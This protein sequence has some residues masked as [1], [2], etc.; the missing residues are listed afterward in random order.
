V[1]TSALVICA[2]FA[3]VG[4]AHGPPSW[5]VVALALGSVPIVA[6]LATR[7]HVSF[8]S[9]AALAVVA[10]AI[11]LLAGA[12]AGAE[13]LPVD[14]G[15][16][17]GARID[18]VVQ[19]ADDPTTSAAGVRAVVRHEGRRLLAQF[20]GVLSPL[21]AD[22]L[23]GDHVRVVG[24]LDTLDRSPLGWRR[25][26]HLVGALRVER[27]A[28]GPP[29]P[30]WMRA[31]NATRRT[32]QHG[33]AGLD[34]RTA[35]LAL[36]LVIGDD[37]GQEDLDRFRFRASGLG[38]LLA[39]SGQNVA[40][41]IVAVGPVLRRL[42]LRWRWLAGSAVVA[43][44]VL[45]TRAEPSVLRAA[46]MAVIALVAASSGRPLDGLRALAATVLVLVLV[47]PMLVHS[48]GFRLSVAATVGLTL[49][50][51]PIANGLPGPRWWRE[52]LGASVAATLATLPLQVMTF[53][54]VPVVGLA[55]NVLAVPVAG[56]VVVA[57]PP[58]AL[59]AGLL[60]PSFGRVLVWPVGLLVEWIDRVATWCSRV[61]VGPVDG[62]RAAVVLAGVA[63]LAAAFRLST[64]HPGRRADV[65]LRA[66]SGLV[67]VVLAVTA[68]VPAPLDAGVHRV[69][70]GAVLQVDD[71]GARSLR[72]ADGA[73][74]LDVLDGLWVVGVHRIDRVEAPG[75]SAAAAAVVEQFRPGDVTA[76]R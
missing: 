4:A 8:R 69:A 10:V 51:A 3:A 47:D 38:H 37:R 52:V 67:G 23:A 15:V 5:T 36:G 19:L 65:A 6:I 54:S 59:V 22:L 74:P 71:D 46:T 72:L 50:A 73:D 35:S 39:V 53:G 64:R 31:A 61:P 56:L 45:V 32:L 2:A 70:G 29:A 43:A 60:H 55:A 24:R 28:P 1:R 17:P 48:V 21:V 18:A 33:L 14:T 16:Q 49:A 26:R 13:R 57:G 66:G 20:P 62:T 42:P 76:G 40:L 58:A 34:E 30:P 7:L 9:A 25:S 68:V 12:R 75:G 44:F 27:A 41:T 11:G 63:L